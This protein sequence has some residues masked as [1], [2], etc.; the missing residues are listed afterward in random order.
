ML[1]KHLLSSLACVAILGGCASAPP[2]PAPKALPTVASFIKDAEAAIA[3]GNNEQA[4]SLLKSAALAYPK[5]KEPR[6]RAAQL[7]FD[8][9]N[10]GE[11]IS[12]ARE[13]LDR[14]PDDMTANSIMAASGLRVSS[15]A[16]ADLAAKNNLSG[17]VRTEAQD[18]V[19]VVRAHIKGDII[20]SGN[21]NSNTTKN[22]GGKRNVPAMSPV[23][24]APVTPLDEW[25]NTK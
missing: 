16:L 20:P 17:T 2:P 1:S 6:L 9:H 12:H 23:V 21:G 13:V 14:D 7:Q 10:Y 11:A 15:K 25:L 24:K 4:V 5:D 19:K 18:L 8:C 22:G 3:V